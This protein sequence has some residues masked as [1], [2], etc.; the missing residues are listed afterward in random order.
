MAD[1]QERKDLNLYQKLLKIT[2][3]IGKIDKTGTNTQQSYK[4]IEQAVVVAEVRVQ[5]AKW[6]VV[7]REEVLDRTVDRFTTKSGANAVHVM[8][9]SRFTV[10][11][12]DNPDENFTDLWSAGEALD[13]SDKA[14]NKATTASEKYYLMKLF[15]I[16]DQN[17]P[18]KENNTV[19]SGSEQQSVQTPVAPART[20]AVTVG[21]RKNVSDKQIQYMFNAVKHEFGVT[22]RDTAEAALDTFAAHVLGVDRVELV[23]LTTIEASK[24][25]S[26][27]EDLKRTNPDDF[28]QFVSVV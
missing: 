12:A 25:I 24:V 18:D 22:D 23:D 15:K 20:A 26:A 16:S 10:I 8:L 17:D 19:E 2:E 11:N 5:L 4:F 13:Y 27:I 1:T 28:K 7:I 6:G 14:S 21:S 3:E 9:N